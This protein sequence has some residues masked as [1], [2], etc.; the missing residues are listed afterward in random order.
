[1]TATSAPTIRTVVNFTLN[2]KPAR[3]E[4]DTLDSLLK[5]LREQLDVTST[6]VGC[7]EGSCGT[8]TVLLDGE[9]RRGCLLPVFVVEGREVTTL[10][11]VGGLND[12]HPL[13]RAFHEQ[14]ASQ[15]GFCTSGMILTAKALLDRTATPSR[16]EIV[17]ALSGNLCRCTGYASIIRAIESVA[18][19]GGSS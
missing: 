1:M 2:G 14:F 10:E 7:N 13:Q 8:C 19:S 12:L 9:P 17:A 3:V 11:G 6:R 4:C 16:A 15:C 18:G 5:I